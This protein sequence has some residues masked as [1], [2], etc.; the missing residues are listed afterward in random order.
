MLSANDGKII[1][2]VANSNR[3]SVSDKVLSGVFGP[4]AVKTI[5]RPIIP[6]AIEAQI[7]TRVA[8]FCM[9]PV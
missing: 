9:S 4:P 5:S 3:I 2:T 1:N 6:K 8:I 7:N